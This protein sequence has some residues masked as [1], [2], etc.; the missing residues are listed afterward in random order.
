M[1]AL[2]PW[3]AQSARRATMSKICAELRNSNKLI[4]DIESAM[5]LLHTIRAGHYVERHRLEE[6]H[7]IA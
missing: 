2:T 7:G 5:A 1:N 3:P 6:R 4:T